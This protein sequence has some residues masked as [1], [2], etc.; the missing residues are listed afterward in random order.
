[1][2][3]LSIIINE[4]FTGISLLVAI[5]FILYEIISSVNFS[6]KLNRPLQKSTQI[7]AFYE[8]TYNLTLSYEALSLEDFKK[9]KIGVKSIMLGNTIEKS[10][11]AVVKIIL[12]AGLTI[13]TLSV[14]LQ[15][16]LL[17]VLSNEEYKKDKLT[18]FTTTEKILS[19]FDSNALQNI[20]LLAGT[21]SLVLIL[22][23]LNRNL[24]NHNLHKHKTIIEEIE[25]ER[26][27]NLPR[28]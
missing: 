12:T 28:F 7:S 20:L 11:E 14:A 18:W 26:E 9:A 10:V 3:Y 8:D 5:G 23:I 27:S 15:S 17:T 1:M 22:N 13:M 21:L 24:K 6:K 19:S 4:N 2:D 25:K 16:S